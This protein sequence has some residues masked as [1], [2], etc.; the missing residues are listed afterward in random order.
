MVKNSGLILIGKVV[1]SPLEAPIKTQPAKKATSNDSQYAIQA[2]RVIKGQLSS[3]AAPVAV[4]QPLDIVVCVRSDPS[5][6]LPVRKIWEDAPPDDPGYAG[7]ALTE[8]R[9]PPRLTKS[10]KASANS[11]KRKHSGTRPGLEKNVHGIFFLKKLSSGSYEF[12]DPGHPVLPALGLGTTGQPGSRPAQSLTGDESSL[13]QTVDELAQVLSSYSAALDAAHHESICDEIVDDFYQI[14]KQITFPVLRP[15]SKSGDPHKRLWITMCML[16]SDGP[17]PS[18]PPPWES[19]DPV[20]DVLVSPPANTN[21]VVEKI[22]HWIDSRN[23]LYGKAEGGPVPL[24]GELLRSSNVA[25]RRAAARIVRGCTGTEG[26]QKSLATQGLNDNDAEV[27]WTSM[28]GLAEI[29]GRKDYCPPEPKYLHETDTEPQY[30]VP[31]KYLD[32]WR[33]WAAKNNPQ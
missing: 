24:M 30:D 31:A 21:L 19:I 10:I 2:E 29:T 7:P 27:R 4:S 11:S 15:L 12:V 6:G 17:Y 22:A 14:P 3:L 28:S 25:I 9:I 26:A 5:T 32:F 18:F 8:E 23:H 33:T 1:H 20:T 13:R 16:T